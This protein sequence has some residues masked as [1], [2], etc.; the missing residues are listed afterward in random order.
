V[1]AASAEDVVSAPGMLVDGHLQQYIANIVSQK[2]TLNGSYAVYVFV[3]DFDDRP[4]EW[5]LSPN[6]AGTHAVSANLMVE[7]KLGAMK[8]AEKPIKVTGAIPLTD[9]LL[10]KVQAGELKSMEGN[11]VEAYLQANLHWRVATVSYAQRMSGACHL[12]NALQFDGVEV[13][14]NNVGDLSITVVSAEVT[15]PA[16]EDAFPEYNNF[17]QLTQITKDRLGGC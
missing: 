2:H 9:M 13:D 16:T 14:M 7:Q 8:A 15:P 12:A 5:P 17:T 10:T 1:K 3:G 11:S 4:C 6:L